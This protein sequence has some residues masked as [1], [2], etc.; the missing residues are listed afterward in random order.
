LINIGSTCHCEAGFSRLKQS[1]LYYQKTAALL[2]A[3]TY[4]LKRFFS[5]ANNERILFFYIAAF[6]TR[7]NS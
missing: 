4:P 5:L 2:T 7:N 3:M 1:Q 6:K